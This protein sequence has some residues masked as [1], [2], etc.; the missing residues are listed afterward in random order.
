MAKSERAHLLNPN[1]PGTALPS[2]PRHPPL[3]LRHGPAPS[4][5]SRPSRRRELDLGESLAVTAD[6][7]WNVHVV[8]HSPQLECLAISVRAASSTLH[9]IALHCIT[10]HHIAIARVPRHLGAR[11]LQYIALH[12]I[13]LHHIT[14]HRHSSSASPSR[15]APPRRR[16]APPPFPPLPPRAAAA[17]RRQ[18]SGSRG[19]SENG[20]VS[21]ARVVAH[22]A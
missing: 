1:E 5:L 10:S 8:A 15:C 6:L 17:P 3:L 2:P 4:L 22:Q 19:S 12:C 21:D 9:C 16:P 7:F 18:A 11:R 20:R 14:S 13:A